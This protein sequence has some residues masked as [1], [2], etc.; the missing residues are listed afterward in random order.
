M[1]TKM[2]LLAAFCAITSVATGA[3]GTKKEGPS[4]AG[5][6]N[7][8]V[9]GPAAHGD[10]SATL[11]LKQD[12]GKVSGTFTMNSRAQ[13]VAG[14]FADGA[15]TIATTDTPSEQALSFNAQLK[16]DGTLMGH[17]S[18]PMGDMGWTASRAKEGK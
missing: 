5:A 15:L 10:V 3:Q 2:V 17:V 12:A 8:L 18:T 4:V 13:P 9:K 7:M 11:E 14:Q 16:A 6:W 1:K